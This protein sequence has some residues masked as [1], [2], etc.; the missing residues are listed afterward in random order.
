MGQRAPL[1]RVI[2]VS[3]QP[4]RLIVG[5]NIPLITQSHRDDSR[6]DRNVWRHQSGSINI[7]QEPFPSSPTSPS[8]PSTPPNNVL[9]SSHAP[10]PHQI[11]LPS[12]PTPSPHL[13]RPFCTQKHIPL[14][15]LNIL[16]AGKAVIHNLSPPQ[17]YRSPT[18]PIYIHM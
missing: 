17:G 1:I 10:S 13:P 6:G 4:V 12:S 5:L 2:S 14:S 16:E 8:L 9:P 18:H 15:S 3:Y 7:V 11:P